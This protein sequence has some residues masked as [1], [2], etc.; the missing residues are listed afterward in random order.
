MREET[1]L[2]E[3]ELDAL[4][5]GRLTPE[6]H[7]S[8]AGHI[9]GCEAC[10]AE[11]AQLRWLRSELRA[12]GARAPARDAA[13]EAR[14]RVAL[15]GEDAV[16]A[17][18]ER[19]APLLRGPRR[20]L[21]ASAAAMTAV[22]LAWLVASPQQ[23]ALPDA[24]AERYLAV[25]GEPAE[26]GLD[27]A[28]LEERFRAGGVAFRARVLD[29]DMLGFRI[30]GGSAFEFGA[31]TAVETLYRDALGQ[32]VLCVMLEDDAAALPAGGERFERG[33]IA[34]ASFRRGDVTV[35]VWSE[36]DLLCLLV[37]A[38]PREELHVLAVAKAMLPS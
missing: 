24:A 21:L 4:L 11:L 37:A 7:A 2:A 23:V 29:L 28:V 22:L 27:A 18:T 13:F 33:G 6:Q 12:V 34:F 3:N 8:A 10:G 31:T 16:R 26:P 5:D 15:D 17:R 36:G 25:R 9:A 14:L 35:V 30:A 19:V 38:L 32:S 1:H 20:W